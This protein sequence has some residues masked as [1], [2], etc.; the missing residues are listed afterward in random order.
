[1]TANILK[2]DKCVWQIYWYKRNRK[3]SHLDLALFALSNEKKKID[4]ADFL[5]ARGDEKQ[6][7]KL[8]GPK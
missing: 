2:V 7:S 8:E 4:A 5:D 3:K 6:I 1:M